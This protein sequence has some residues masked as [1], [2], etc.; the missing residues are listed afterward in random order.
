MLEKR[1]D[2][3]LVEKLRL[4]DQPAFEELLSRYTQKVH[5]LCIRITRNAQDAEEV[6]QDVFVAIYRKIDRFE[7][8]SAFSSWL[9][10]ITVNTAFMKLRKRRQNN[11]LSLDELG[12]TIRDNIAGERSDMRD[13]N[14]I[15]SRHQL[16]EELENAIKK[17]PEEYRIIFILRDIDGLSNQEVGEI[18]H[19]SVPAVKSRLHRSRLM[20]RK[21]LQRF[22]DD[23][24]GSEIVKGTINY[25]D[26]EQRLAA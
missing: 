2:S 13:V 4:G 1:T 21:R 19:L 23:Y 17:L 3:E 24:V 18:V 20:L 14:F 5:N 10:R 8:K 11:T 9:Y 6:M 15:S 12:P 25:G 22:Y 7:G 26:E 16:R